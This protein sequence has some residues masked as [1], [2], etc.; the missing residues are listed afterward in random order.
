MRNINIYIEVLKSLSFAILI[1]V[2]LILILTPI[3]FLVERYIKWVIKKLYME[4][5][6]KE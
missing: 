4:D 3:Y 5:E 1:A 2:I 6:I